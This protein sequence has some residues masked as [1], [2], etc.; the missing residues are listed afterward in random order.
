M[1]YLTAL[2]KY[3]TVRGANFS[4]SWC[5]FYCDAFDI[6][7][8]HR[9]ARL[10]GLN[11]HYLVDN[12]NFTFYWV[13]RVKRE[14]FELFRRQKKIEWVQLELCDYVIRTGVRI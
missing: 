3:P 4:D 6:G 7:N 9:V 5:A 8:L 14:I 12:E 10:C 13:D 11:T 1:L 2:T